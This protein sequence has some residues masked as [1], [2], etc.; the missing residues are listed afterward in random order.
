MAIP[1]DTVKPIPLLVTCANIG[2]DYEN[3]E[4]SKRGGHE[5]RLIRLALLFEVS[6]YGLMRCGKPQLG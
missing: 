2:R 1:T 4:V 3:S 5:Q 6:E